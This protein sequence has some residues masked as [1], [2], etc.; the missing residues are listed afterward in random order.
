MFTAYYHQKP[1]INANLTEIDIIHR[2]GKWN[3]IL[4]EMAV[5]ELSLRSDKLPAISGLATALQIPEMGEYLAG[6]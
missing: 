2:L 5:R 3:S 1:S 4:Q 6:V